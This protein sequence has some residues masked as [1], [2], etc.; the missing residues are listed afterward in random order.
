MTIKKHKIRPTIGF[1]KCE[2]RLISVCDITYAFKSGDILGMI[3]RP[4]IDGLRA[5]AILFVLLFH[6]GLKLFPSG[7][8][9]V[10]IFFVIS[11]F[12]IT[13]IIH[14]SLQNNRFSFTE[15][16]SRRLWRLQP[17]LLCLIVLTSLVT[18]FF[19]LP[20]DLMHYFKSARKTTLFISNTFFER[21]TTD[22]F[23]ANNNQLPLLHTWSL[24]IEWQCYLLLPIALYLL[25]R[26]F[27]KSHMSRVIYLL[28]LLFL[29]ASL[30][31]SSHY[32][33]KTYYQV[34]SR[35]FEFLIGSCV[36]LS[37]HRIVLNKYFLELISV[38]AI[39][40]L[41][42][43]ATRSD[44]N[45]G[46]PNGYA[47]VLC[48]ATGALLALGQQSRQSL[49]TRLLSVKP[50][51]F[52]G[53]I[54]YSLYIWHWP[55]FVLI[56]YLDIKETTTVLL[57]AFSFVFIL[58]YCS[59]RFIEKPARQ[60]HRIKWGYTLL[61][62]FIIPVL[63]IHLC[64]Y[65][66]QKHEGYPQR[67]EEIVRVD[68]QLKQYAS[69]QRTLC[70]QEKSVEVNP[71]CHVGVKNAAS[72]TALMIG[73]SYSNHFWGFM[74]TLAQKANVSILAHA[75]AAC[76]SLPDVTQYDWNIKRYQA[77]HEQTE[78]YFKMIKEN[79]YDFVIIGQNWNGYLNGKLII[80]N[81]SIPAKEY[82][83]DALDKALAI[84]VTSGSRPVLIKSIALSGNPHE[85][86][87]DHIKR[88][89]AYDAKQCDFNLAKEQE[90]QQWQEDMFLRM[91]N[92]YA[93]LII[94]DPK[95]VQC[96]EGLCKTDI[97]G[98]PVFRDAGHLTDY[99][100]YRLAG[101][102]LQ[103]YKNPL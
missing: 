8:I 10:D 43:I 62:L 54:S 33:G 35:I 14:T 86:F 98:V 64:D 87:F 84:I 57:L 2:F 21:V 100:S 89:R 61:Y 12:L 58:A 11:G 74:D 25:Y 80:D 1:A 45:V 67:F 26:V 69:V 52:I 6:G 85:C 92:K 34:L 47:V 81:P 102:Y 75:T 7:F 66:I 29:V 19:Y 103:R 51:V 3:Y 95:K 42:Y 18:L 68:A 94:I 17:V 38:S 28:T 9:G 91:K 97:D 13:T 73:D 50:V 59:W 60:F 39:I 36:A 76:L 70:L 23:S 15:F 79:H 5:I 65:A 83:E 27:G 56:R 96:P 31:C 46:F 16:Y 90:K 32:P 4:D 22:Y 101:M 93:Q 55:V 37:A 88:G 53:L 77:C 41:F 78:R 20:D 44:I 71:D 63:I 30:Y 72:K 48:I 40:T 24:S 99:A 82:I 49:S